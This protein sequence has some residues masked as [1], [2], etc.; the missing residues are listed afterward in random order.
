M[1]TLERK[2]MSAELIKKTVKGR[3]FAVV[4]W[5]KEFNRFKSTPNRSFTVMVI[6]TE[7]EAQTI[8]DNMVTVDGKEYELEMS[9]DLPMAEINAKLGGFDF[10]EDEPDIYSDDD[11]K[12]RYV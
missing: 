7:D 10:L 4:D 2:E 9:P 12:K 8:F 6:E 5:V 3:D 1:K 11:L